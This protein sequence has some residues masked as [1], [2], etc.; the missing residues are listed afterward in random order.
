MLSIIMTVY[1][2]GNYINRTLE[3]L[4]KQKKYINDVELI[5]IDDKSTDNTVNEIVKY[6]FPNI[7]LIE[8]DRKISTGEC[9][10]IGIK[11]A[12]NEFIC[13]LDGDDLINLDVAFKLC[14]FM[15]SY[16][17]N[18]GI[19]GYQTW[20]WRNKNII[21]TKKGLKGYAIE[22]KVNKYL[23]YNP[24]FIINAACWNKIYRKDFILKNK[25]NFADINYG[26]DYTFT[27][28]SILNEN[29]VVYFDEPMIIYTIPKSNPNSNDMKSVETWRQIFIAFDNIYC[30][31]KEN[32]NDYI[33]LLDRFILNCIGHLRYA[34][35]KISNDDLIE[36]NE[37]A[38]EYLSK[39][40]Y[41]YEFLYIGRDKND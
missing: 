22:K 20:D 13:F 10:N 26:E 19:A 17:V 8:L 4:Q 41:E 25:I 36:F 6:K 9:R 3:H 27:I 2:M 39:L 30:Y 40:Q 37:K 21:E 15:N 29:S 7:K 12:G 16:L 38:F 5:I 24:F 18:I 35:T 34:K 1:N 11:M 31:I 28:K 23:I 14:S 33:K 32:I